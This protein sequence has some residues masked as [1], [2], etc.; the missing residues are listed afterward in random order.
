MRETT[1]ELTKDPIVLNIMDLLQEQNKSEQDLIAWLGLAQGTFSKWKYHNLHNYNRYI[2]KIAEFLEVPEIAIVEGVDN[3]IKYEKKPILNTDP[4][5]VRIL[6][7]MKQ[8]NVTAVEMENYIGAASGTFSNWKR[9][10]GR[11][12]Y[13]FIDKFADRFGVT[14]DYLVRGEDL[15]TDALSHQ[16]YEVIQNYR[17]LSEEGKK[18]ISANIKLLAGVT[19]P[20]AINQDFNQDRPQHPQEA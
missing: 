13:S 6:D 14:I 3:Y 20:A 5:F 19:T 7:L 15:K 10:I 12:Y 2:D 11:L 18:V 4:T 17:K 9:G 16:E 8:H 1:R